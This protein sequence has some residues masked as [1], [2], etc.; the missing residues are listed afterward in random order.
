MQSVRRRRH[1]DGDERHGVPL[2]VHHQ[3]GL[4]GRRAGGRARVGRAGAAGN[5][6]LLRGAPVRGGLGA[7]GPGAVRGRS[8]RRAARA[9]A[10]RGRVLRG[11]AR[12]HRGDG[13]ARPAGGAGRVQPTGGHGR[14]LSGVPRRLPRAPRNAGALVRQ[15]VF[16]EHEARQVARA[17]VARGAPGRGAGGR[18]VPHPR[19]AAVARAARPHGRGAAVPGDAAR[20]RRT[21]PRRGRGPGRRGASRL[22]RGRHDSRG[23]RRGRALG[24]RRARAPQG[25]R[26]RHA[27]AA[28]LG[29]QRRHLLLGGHPGGR[30]HAGPGP[31][32]RHRHGHPG[33]GPRGVLKDARGRPGARRGGA[34]AFPRR[35]ARKPQVVMTGVA[36]VLMDRA[37]RRALLAASLGGMTFAAALMAVYFAFLESDEASSWV[38]VLALA[39]YISFFSIGL[40]PIPWLLMPEILPQRARGV[41]SAAAT[42]LNWTCSFAVTMS[43]ANLLDV[44]TPQG[45]FLLFAAVCCAGGFYVIARVPETKGLTLDEISE[46]F[47]RRAST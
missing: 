2:V 10:G 19:V 40:G 37:G 47:R 3:R 29:H 31:R 30:G 16:Q 33:A 38:A 14:H 20:R 32:R 8:D 46:V 43:F 17:R 34:P 45:A 25:G 23:A 7:D 26:R 27:R 36:V 18:R 15:G 41:A 39:L 4:H 42:L 22:G 28:V 13:A 35:A 44:L 6:G 12:V 9:G 24:P 1:R 11:R 21:R 5:F